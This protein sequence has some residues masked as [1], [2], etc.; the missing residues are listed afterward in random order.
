MVLIC[1]DGGFSTSLVLDPPF[2]RTAV[3]KATR[4]ELLHRHVKGRFLICMGEKVKRPPSTRPFVKISD[5]GKS[6]VRSWRKF[7]RIG[8]IWCRFW[9]NSH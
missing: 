7:Q 4:K 9:T 2:Y 3:R 5:K 1:F 8:C 6:L